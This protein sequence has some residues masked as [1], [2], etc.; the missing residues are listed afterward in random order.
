MTDPGVLG[1]MTVQKM[2]KVRVQAILNFQEYYN[3]FW[4][5]TSTCSVSAEEAGAV[6]ESV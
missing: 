5:F 1:L 4:R 2:R 3:A 6:D